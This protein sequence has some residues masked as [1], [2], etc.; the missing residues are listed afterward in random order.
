MIQTSIK[1]LLYYKR[2][3]FEAITGVICDM[4]ENDLEIAFNTTLE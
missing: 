2:I 4:I 1:T 3:Y